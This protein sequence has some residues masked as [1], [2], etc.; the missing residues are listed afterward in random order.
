MI[1]PLLLL[2]LNSTA[3]TAPRGEALLTELSKKSVA[4]FWE[5]SNPQTGF[6]LDRAPNYPGAAAENATISSI[7]ATGYALSAYCIGVD[8]GWLGRAEAKKRTVLTLGNVLTKLQGNKGWY[9]HFVDWTT[10]KREWNSELS[11]ID[12]ALLFAGVEMARGYWA[13]PEVSKLCDQIMGRVDWH[14]FLT[15]GGKN[16]NSLTFSMGW[17]PENG[18]LEARWNG[19]YESM[20]L[21]IIALGNDDK[22]EPEIWTAFRRSRF[23]WQGIDLLHG[24]ALFIHQMSQAYLPMQGKR[25]VLGYD[26]WVEGRNMTLANRLYCKLN[27]RGFKAYGPDI[28]GLS[29]C[30]I[31]GGYGAPG[32][33]VPSGEPFDN[34]T[35][36]PAS[37]VA[38]V[39]YAPELSMQ[40]ADAYVT[41]LPESYGRYGFTTG[42]N[43]SQG[44]KSTHV[45]GIDI[46]QMMLA[47]EAHQNGKPYK[48]MMSNPRI[49]KGMKRA[50]FHETQEGP[51]E[52]RPLYLQPY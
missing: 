23:Q 29:A 40:A 6:T 30:D 2:A 12:S 9:F 28:W 18:F 43:P 37:A 7:A 51:L 15:D 4:Y 8:R 50:G 31:P 20:F 27:P 34:G 19:F 52:S 17:S 42:I 11:T 22:L 25:D 16:M 38:S 13:D 3:S 49:A 1:Q 33:P 47:I 41:Q 36:A 46:G 45:I 14:W 35:L 44:W 48:W 21:Y 39:M 24:A 10:G 26:Y 5:N 32:A